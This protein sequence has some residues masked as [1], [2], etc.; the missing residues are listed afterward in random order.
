MRRYI[1]IG[2]LFVSL[3]TAADLPQP[4][5]LRAVMYR[6]TDSVAAGAT[7]LLTGQTVSSSAAP[8]DSLDRSY[9]TIL[10]QGLSAAGVRIVDRSAAPA[11]ELTMT[12]RDASVHH[13]DPFSGSFFGPE[14][15]VRTARLSVMF[16]AVP[17]QQGAEGWTREFTASVTDTVEVNSIAALSE[18]APPLTSIVMPERSWFE[19]LIEPAIVTVAAGVAVYLFF[20]IRS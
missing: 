19:T 13:A 2:L 5:A 1:P 20:T 10:L 14:L 16:T 18:F 11:L 15:T 4:A 8:A 7:R 12:V 6:L 3:C 9:H 17:L